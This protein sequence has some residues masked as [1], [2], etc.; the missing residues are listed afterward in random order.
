MSMN[1]ATVIGA[2]LAG[3]E[4]A[5]QLANAGVEVTLVE[6]KPVRR[7]PAHHADNF[8]ELVC[9]NS[10]KARRLESAAG[11]LKEEMRRLGSICVESALK[12]AVPAGGALAVDREAFSA[13]VT[14]AVRSHPNITIVCEECVA[15][16]DQ[17]ICVI[18][19]GPL[20]S[21]ALADDIARRL[22]RGYLS[23][24]DAAAPIVA[25]ESVDM[26]HAFAASRYERGEGEGDY[27]NC[28]MNREEYEGFYDALISAESV[29]LKAF[30]QSIPSDAGAFASNSSRAADERLKE[31]VM[32]KTADASHGCSHAQVRARSADGAGS[33]RMEATSAGE[34]DFKP[35]A[36]QDAAIPVYKG[37]MPI[38]V[39]ARRGRDTIRFGPLKP[40]GLRDPRT[41]RR[42]WAV[43]QLRRENVAGSMYNLVGFQTNLRFSEQKRVFSMIPALHHA[44]FMRYGVMHRNTFLDSPRLLEPSY[45]LRSD[46][47]IFFA[48]QITGVEGHRVIIHKKS[49][50]ASNRAGSRISIL[51]R[52]IVVLP[53]RG[54]DLDFIALK[55]K[56][57]LIFEECILFICIHDFMC[58]NLSEW[59][60]TSKIFMQGAFASFAVA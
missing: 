13:M 27:L 17:G 28:P 58:L 56:F 21:G 38:E 48:G 49:E 15:L 40:V 19:T 47:R 8:A 31:T 3:C 33:S 42:P 57:L 26:A 59:K 55:K 50:A 39:M 7:S 29:S 20:T 12:C 44:E 32:Q 6:Q 54:C 24:Y 53:E 30:E 23:F 36:G 1:H 18:A 37:C 9:S 52:N 35:S 16:P 43:V 5:L 51:A 25:A 11:L 45:R 34:G 4:A 41:G 14:K 2:G 22:G 10:L 60:V 46:E